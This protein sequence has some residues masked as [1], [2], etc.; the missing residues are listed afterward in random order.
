MLIGIPTEY[1]VKLEKLINSRI[2][3]M[4]S[5]G[6]RSGCKRSCF[7][8]QG[9]TGNAE[10]WGMKGKRLF[11][12]TE[13]EDTER[14]ALLSGRGDLSVSASCCDPAPPLCALSI[15]CCLALCIPL[16]VLS[17]MDEQILF[18]FGI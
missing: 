7:R 16:C 2:L 1:E 12:A 6:E 9:L 4:T 15:I 17:S 18:T 14:T 11:M 8:G 5:R 3:T 10:R 13:E